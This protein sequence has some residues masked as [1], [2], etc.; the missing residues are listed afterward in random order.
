LKKPEKYR[1]T[2]KL[3]LKKFKLQKRTFEKQESYEKLRK[4]KKLMK[5]QKLEKKI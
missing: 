4:L 2:K 3:L 1:K 5:L